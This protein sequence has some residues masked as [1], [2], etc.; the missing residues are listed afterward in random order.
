M[1]CSKVIKAILFR[2]IEALAIKKF[3]PDL[4][5]RKQFILILQ[6]VIVAW[7]ITYWFDLYEY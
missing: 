6:I 2:F 7:A 3:N 5:I 1:C 4:C